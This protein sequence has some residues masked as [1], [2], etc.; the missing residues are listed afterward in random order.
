MQSLSS[1]ATRHDSQ[2]PMHY[3]TGEVIQRGDFVLHIH[4]NS[5]GYYVAAL[6]ARVWQPLYYRDGSALGVALVSGDASSE[7]QVPQILFSREENYETLFY[8]RAPITIEP[9]AIAEQLHFFQHSKQWSFQINTD[10]FQKQV[11]QLAR[12]NNPL[13]AFAVGLWQRER[14]HFNKAAQ[15]FQ[16]AA[17]QHF[18]PAYIELGLLHLKDNKYQ[19]AIDCFTHLLQTKQTSH[20]YFMAAFL[21]AQHYIQGQGVEADEREAFQYLTIAMRGNIWLAWFQMAMFHL[22]GSFDNFRPDSHPLRHHFKNQTDPKLAIPLLQRLA[23]ENSS[24]RGAAAF[25]LANLLMNGKLIEKNSKEAERLF[26]IASHSNG[27]SDEE[28][29]FAMFNCR[30]FNDIEQWLEQNVMNPQNTA[31]AHYY[32]GSSLMIT[33]PKKAHERLEI[34]ANAGYQP[35]IEL[36]NKLQI[37]NHAV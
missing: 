36:L 6:P 14:Q 26:A 10:I 33:Q 31:L 17:K 30:K 19:E 8:Y 35:A 7:E 23:N 29:L 37:D 9:A 21:L 13:A 28:R 1:F 5:D 22:S 12:Q 16:T 32:I 4:T 27:L 2:T 3:A 34:A 18:L 24:I 11:A 20:P 25:R 15:C